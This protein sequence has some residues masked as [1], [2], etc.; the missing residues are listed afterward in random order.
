MLGVFGSYARSEE[1]KNSDIDL[2]IDS[3]TQYNLLDLIGVEQELTEKLGVKVDL[4]TLRS[5]NASLKSY[6]EADL[7]RFV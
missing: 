5:I 4:I 1:T 2:L 3:K 6:I 7:I